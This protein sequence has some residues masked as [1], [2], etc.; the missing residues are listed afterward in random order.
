[1]YTFQHIHALPPRRDASCNHLD[2]HCTTLGKQKQK[3]HQPTVIQI[4]QKK[5][6]LTQQPS[7][8]ISAV[9]FFV[10]VTHHPGEHR[11]TASWL[12]ARQL[13]S[14]SGHLPSPDCGPTGRSAPLLL[15]NCQIPWTTPKGKENEGKWLNILV[16]NNTDLKQQTGLCLRNGVQV[17]HSVIGI[18]PSRSK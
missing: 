3:T 7:N 12:W 4:T 13:S 17:V 18:V 2:L 6:I 15:S 9:C 11:C 5:K 1:M 8:L 10:W 16:W 14:Q